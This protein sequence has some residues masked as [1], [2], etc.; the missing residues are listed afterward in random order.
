MAL[1][2][3]LTLAHR[4]VV[5]LVNPIAR[6]QGVIRLRQIVWNGNRWAETIG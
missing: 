2:A 4:L 3:T 1:H 5:R 6:G